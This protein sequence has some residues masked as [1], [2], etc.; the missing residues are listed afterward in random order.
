VTIDS[1]EELRDVAA[2]ILK[3]ENSTKRRVAIISV[4]GIV[5][6]SAGVI[7][8]ILLQRSTQFG[9]VLIDSRSQPPNI[10]ITI[11]PNIPAGNISIIGSDGKTT[12]FTP[13]ELSGA[14]KKK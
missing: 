4:A 14:L 13:D 10:T 12:T 6:I 11:D 3:R 8:F 9:G 1:E 5:L 2:T 7:S